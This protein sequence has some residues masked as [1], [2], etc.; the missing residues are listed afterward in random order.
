MEVLTY[1][2]RTLTEL[3]HVRLARLVRSRSPHDGLRSE[4]PIDAMPD[5]AQLVSSREVAPD[6]V[7]M[8]SHVELTDDATGRRYRLTGCYPSDANP[9]AGFVSALSPVGAAVLGLRVGDFAR[10]CL[11]NGKQAAAR[12]TALLFQPEDCG[13]YT[14]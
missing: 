10:W 13:D 7:T 4:C 6:M 9:Q 1:D 8:Y 14:S 2:D 5:T 3:D 12:V 11:P